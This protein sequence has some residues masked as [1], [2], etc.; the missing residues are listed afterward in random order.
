MCQQ[1][2]IEEF[3]LYQ[4]MEIVAGDENAYAKIVSIDDSVLELHITF[5]SE[6]FLEMC[7]YVK[8]AENE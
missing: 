7:G 4:D 1:E 2:N 8:G 3:A 5:L 6:H